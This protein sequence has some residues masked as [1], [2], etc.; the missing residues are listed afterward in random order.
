MVNVTYTESSS[1]MIYTADDGTQYLYNLGDMSFVI[2]AMAL[3][4]IMVP[5]VG[6]FYSGLLRR[7]NALSMIFLSMAGVAV[8]SFQWFFWDTLATCGTLV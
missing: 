8:G 6:L 2:V 1:D 5:G 4:W 7:K 3:V